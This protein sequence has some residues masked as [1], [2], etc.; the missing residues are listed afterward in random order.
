MHLLRDTNNG[1]TQVR[2]SEDPNF[3]GAAWQ[4]LKAE[5]SFQLA[6]GRAEPFTAIVYA[7][8]RDAAG[9]ESSLYSVATVVD[10][11]GDEESDG[12]PNRTDPDHDENGWSDQDELLVHRTDPFKADTDGDGIPD[13]QDGL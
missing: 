7:Q 5:I 8:F 6:S 2:V 4:A 10:Q 13:P 9:N 3:A 11:N 12:L 1:V